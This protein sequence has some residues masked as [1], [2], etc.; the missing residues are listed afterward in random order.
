MS[1]LPRR[2]VNGSNNTFE[3]YLARGTRGKR[4]F[5]SAG[6]HDNGEKTE[7]ERSKRSVEQNVVLAG[8]ILPV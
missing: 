2:A 5:S 4:S 6:E 8:I 3:Y 1:P 7:R